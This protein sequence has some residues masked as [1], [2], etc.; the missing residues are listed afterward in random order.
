MI[1]RDKNLIE[2]GI[3]PAFLKGVLDEHAKVVERY[4]EL[5]D[6]YASKPAITERRVLEGMPNNKLVHNYARYIVAVASGYLVGNPVTYQAEEGVPIDPLLE[7]YAAARVDSVDAELAKDASLYGKAVELAYADEQARPQVAALDPRSAFV[8]YGNDVASTPLLGVRMY[9]IIGQDGKAS[10]VEV[11]VYTEMHEF[12]YRGKDQAAAIKAT[13]EETPHFFGHLPMVEY[14]NND[15]ETG[16][17]EHVKALI[18][19]Y[20]LLQSDRVNDK[21]Q[22]VQSILVLTGARMEAEP[23]VLDEDGNIKRRG[24][25]AAEQLRQDKMLQLP[26]TDATANYLTKQLAEGDVE[27]LRN[28]IKSDIHKFSMVPDLT[29]EHFAGNVSGVAMRYKLFGLEQLTKVK[30]RWFREALQ[31]RIKVFAGFLSVKGQAS[32]DPDAVEIVFRRSLPAND[33]ELANMVATLKGMVPTQTL[34]GQLPFVQD[35]AL[36]EQEL[37]EQNAR[38]LKNQQAAFGVPLAGDDE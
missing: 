5:A 21:E 23:D 11:I 9:D 20:D 36:A 3:S 24:R 33:L 34:L 26:D 4:N 7:A 30:E 29:D 12:V 37:E 2:G 28:A 14:W 31:E 17:F 6:I 27:I 38:A 25:T 1:V 32:I 22:F 10:G 15:D 35:P 18:D 13:P 16:D 19:A 8:V